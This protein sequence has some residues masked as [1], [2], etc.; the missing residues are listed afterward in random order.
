LAD[1]GLA[2]EAE[3]ALLACEWSGSI[4][5]RKNVM[6]LSLVVTMCVFVRA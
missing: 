2:L 4:G 3:A 1:V 6:H 5:E